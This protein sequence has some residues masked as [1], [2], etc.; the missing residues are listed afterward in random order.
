MLTLKKVY[1]GRFRWKPDFNYFGQQ[2][3][4][5]IELVGE[6]AEEQK[7]LNDNIGLKQEENIN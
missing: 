3:N 7:L 2:I 5:L 4:D 1:N 6:V